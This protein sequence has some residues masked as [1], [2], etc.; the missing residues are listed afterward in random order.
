MNRVN[1]KRVQT[2]EVFQ[3]FQ[4]ISE[5]LKSKAFAFVERRPGRMPM[6]L[7]GLLKIS[8]VVRMF[9]VL[10][11]FKTFFDFLAFLYRRFCVVN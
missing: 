2:R 4:N 5:V 6:S 9:L 10:R 3:D 11:C 7:V 1:S 8:R